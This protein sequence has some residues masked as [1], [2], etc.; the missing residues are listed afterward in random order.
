MNSYVHV[1]QTHNLIDT[2]PMTRVSTLVE[3]LQIRPRPFSVPTQQLKS[4]ALRPALNRNGSNRTTVIRYINAPCQRWWIEK[5][6]LRSSLTSGS[7]R[8]ATLRGRS[9]SL[10][11]QAWSHVEAAPVIL[12]NHSVQKSESCTL[13]SVHRSWLTKTAQ[14]SFLYREYLLGRQTSWSCMTT[15][16]FAAGMIWFGRSVFGFCFF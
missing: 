11:L 7:K 10:S 13:L 2:L 1:Q 12:S 3:K 9:H 6:M 15:S 16:H 4:T 8:A 5:K 14:N